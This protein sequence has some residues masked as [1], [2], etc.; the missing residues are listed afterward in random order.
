M[1][2]GDLSSGVKT[3]VVQLYNKC[4]KTHIFGVCNL[5]SPKFEFLPIS[6]RHGILLDSGT[7]NHHVAKMNMAF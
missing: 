2:I 6:L 4:K 1:D 3:L 5:L 7:I